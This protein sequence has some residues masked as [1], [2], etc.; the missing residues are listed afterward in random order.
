MTN[1]EKIKEMSIDELAEY[2]ESI[3][4][5]SYCPIE[6]CACNY[7]YGSIKEWLENEV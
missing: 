2:I 3:T 6:E 7:C 1:Y 4:T 5:C